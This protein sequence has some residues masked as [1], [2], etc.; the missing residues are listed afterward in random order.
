MPKGHLRSVKPMDPSTL[1]DGPFSVVD[2][3]NT[4]ARE[5]EK[6]TNLGHNLPQI[7]YFDVLQ[8]VL[9]GKI[10]SSGAREGETMNNDEILTKYIDKVDHDQSQ[11]RDDIRESERRTSD[12][13]RGI[14]ER[15]DDRTAR[16]EERMDNRLNRIEDA[17]HEILGQ[18]GN[19]KDYV[20]GQ[21]VD[22]KNEI[23]NINRE[24]HKISVTVM[25]GVGA[26]ALAILVPLLFFILGTLPSLLKALGK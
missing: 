11:L 18:I 23:G 8:R 4:A 20:H 13:I 9:G 10:E 22:I 7:D 6:Q 14:E 3:T 25:V 2:Q 1:S 26:I 17:N 5:E 15:I 21:V 16:I 19:L 12:S 24:F